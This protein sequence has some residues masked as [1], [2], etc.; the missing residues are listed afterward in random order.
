MDGQL[1]IL[2][3][4]RLSEQ[5]RLDARYSP[6]I[7][8]RLGQFATPYLLAEQ[9][10]RC[11]LQLRPTNTPIRF[12]ETSVGTGVFFSALKQI[13]NP[14][15][16]QRAVGIEIDGDVAQTAQDLWQ[17]HGLEVI[18]ADFTM[19]KS[20]ETFNLV[21]GNP[22]YVRHHHLPKEQKS[23]LY[24]AVK[25]S[26]GLEI[27]GLAGLYIYFILLTNSYLSDGG[28]AA[29]LVPSEFMDV[30]YG[31]ILRRFFSRTVTLRRIHRFNPSDM[32]FDDALVSSTV[33]IYEKKHPMPSQSVLISYGGTLDKPDISEQVSF[34]TLG[35]TKKWSQFPTQ[36][37]SK[38]IQTSVQ[39]SLRLKDLFKIQRGI[40]TGA[41]DFFI[42]SRDN[43]ETMGLPAQFLCPILPSPRY[44]L[45]T[46]I[47]ADHLGFPQV[48]PQSVLIDCPLSPVEIKS[49]YPLLWDYFE[50]G[51]K[52][53]VHQGYLTSRR[54]PWY[55]QE[56]REPAPFLCSYMGRSQNG[57]SPFR[58]FW[59]RSQAIAPNVYLMLYPIN[60]LAEYLRQ[61]PSFH[62]EI[63]QL[64]RAIDIQSI[65]R[66]GRVYGGA[67]HKIEP[68]ELGEVQITHTDKFTHPV[69]QLTLI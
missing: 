44:I 4:R 32:Q 46:E 63:H 68:H 41:N 45:E 65:T 34:K 10:T 31:D 52:K 2:E 56:Q 35:E 23:L 12:L 66:E 24:Q 69:R 25:Q 60:D 43:A 22:P 55:R 58:F 21:I 17:N 40:V 29:W 16:I 48:T 38:P 67:L 47:E 53:G 1:E 6:I 37:K 3:Q 28:I 20:P 11:V 49:H 64:L 13:L 30:N 61:D 57:K 42:L 26:T 51:I 33:V 36:S 15:S 19:L 14:D 54:M 8:N 59:N 39:P 7:R 18:N 50:G 5:I 62:T 27:S 9:I